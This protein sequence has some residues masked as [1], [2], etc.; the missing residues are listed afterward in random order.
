[1][2]WGLLLGFALLQST[3]Q[4]FAPGVVSTADPEFAASISP[5]GTSLYF[6]RASADRSRLSILVARSRHGQWS[7]PETAPF[8]GTHRDV[9]PFVSPDGERLYFSSSRPTGPG[10]ETPDFNTWFVVIEGEEWSEP[11]L[12]PEP[13][14]TA[15]QETFVSVDREGTLYF[16][17]DRDGTQRVWRSRSVAGEYEAPRVVPFAMNLE[18]GASNPWISSSGKLLIFVAGRPGA[19]DSDLYGTCL[20]ESGWLP[21]QNLGAAVNSDFADFAPSLTPDGLYLLFTSERPGVVPAV[22]EGARPPGD[23]YRIELGA[24]ELPCR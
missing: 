15:S 21:G 5:D 3:P 14:N 2:N 8:S 19:Q 9:D 1:M 17:S 10:D 16:G 11:S 4:I 18:D 23:L 24:L 22:A 13:L 6:N 7:P 12:L 20:E